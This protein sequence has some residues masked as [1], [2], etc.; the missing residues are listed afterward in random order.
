LAIQTIDNK[1]A[2]RLKKEITN[3]ELIM[4]PGLKAENS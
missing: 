2:T 4:T 3:E 1:I